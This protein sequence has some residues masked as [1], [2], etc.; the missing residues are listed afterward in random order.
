[1]SI[2]TIDLMDNKRYSVEWTII[3]IRMLINIFASISFHDRY[4]SKLRGNNDLLKIVTS[5][6][7]TNTE[8]RPVDQYIPRSMENMTSAVNIMLYN[9]QDI[10]DDEVADVTGTN[11]V[12]DYQD[13]KPWIMIS[14]NHDDE[15]FCDKILRELDK[16]RQSI[17]CLD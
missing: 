2:L 4:K 9:I 15:Q 8:L 13:E 10:S 5:I 12:P 1:M 7:D 6:A 17:S 16:K 3:D 11:I 14:Y